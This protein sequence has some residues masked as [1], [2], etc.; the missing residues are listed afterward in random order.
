VLAGAEFELQDSTG[1]TLQTGLTTN[2]QG[3]LTVTDLE[4]GDYQLVE[5]K[6]PAGYELDS[7]PVVFTIGQNSTNVSVT[8]ENTKIPAIPDK[9]LTPDTL[10]MPISRT[11]IK[12]TTSMVKLPK[13]GDTPLQSDLGLLLVALSTGSLI[14]LRKNRQG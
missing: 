12:E 5:T 2:E 11:V 10:E 3:I 4:L 8:K 6:A 1:K 7:T 13:T 14:L 9:P